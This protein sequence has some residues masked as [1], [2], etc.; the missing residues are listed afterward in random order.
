M[1]AEIGT[2]ETL[3]GGAVLLVG[4]GE[5]GQD[6]VDEKDEPASGAQQPRRLGKPAVGVAPDA[7][8][9]LGDGEVE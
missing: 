8:A 1:H 5:H 3:A 6:A 7:R 9:V 4:E 2:Q